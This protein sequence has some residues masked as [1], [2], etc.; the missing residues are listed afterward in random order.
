MEALNNR[1]IA[2]A[3]WLLLLIGY[4]LAK[5]KTRESIYQVLKA[6]LHFKILTPLILFITYTTALIILLSKIDLWEIYLLKDTVLWVTLVGIALFFRFGTSKKPQNLFKEII[7][8]NIS[9]I[10]FIEFI[11][12]T[13]TFS[14]LGEILF[15]PVVTFIAILNAFA[16]LK[17]E[18]KA[19]K[20][21][22]ENLLA[23][24]GLVIFSIAVYKAVND[25]SALNNIES[26]KSVLLPIVLTLLS[27]PFYYIYVLFIN[28]EQLFLK[29]DVGRE[30]SNKIKRAAKKKIFKHC[31]F[32]LRKT[33]KAQ[34]MSIFN[35]MSIKDEADIQK[36][37]VT[38][39]SEL[40]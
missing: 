19:V 10:V 38:Y 5:Q 34:N 7:I 29:L 23:I 15:I 11:F 17:K 30:K 18:H 12:N 39:K 25:F 40:E 21:L 1:E 26:L 22:T 16:E 9:I 35:L 32:S 36:L 28:Y 24:I 13:Y 14:L 33:K 8:D 20:K 3:F 37:D 27:F 31:L 2:V 4:F 6:A